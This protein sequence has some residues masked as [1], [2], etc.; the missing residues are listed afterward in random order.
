MTLGQASQDIKT[1]KEAAAP[2]AIEAL[3]ALR[4]NEARSFM[5]K[6][7]HEFAVTPASESRETLDY[8]KRT[9][10]QERAAGF[11]LS[12][13]MDAPAELEGKFKFARQKSRL[14]GTIRGSFFV[15]KG[16]Y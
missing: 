11:K 10:K 8:V 15:I 14:A 9:L 5:N 16:E 7:G 13:A 3:A 2:Q 1:L 6:C 4:V 12:E